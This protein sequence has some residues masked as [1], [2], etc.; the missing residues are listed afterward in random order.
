MVKNNERGKGSPETDLRTIRNWLR[1]ISE[2]ID[3]SFPEAAVLLQIASKMTIKAPPKPDAKRQTAIALQ[4][5][6]HEKPAR[7]V[8]RLR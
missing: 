5:S 8:A 6:E 4:E 2:D 7:I 1:Y 3:R